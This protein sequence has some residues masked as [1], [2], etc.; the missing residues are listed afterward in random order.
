[1]VRVE[2][3]RAADHQ[4]LRDGEVCPVRNRDVSIR[5]GLTNR[6]SQ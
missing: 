4:P 1:M 6:P 3:H 5:K 2:D